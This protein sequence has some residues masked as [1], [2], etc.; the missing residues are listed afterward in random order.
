MWLSCLFAVL[1]GPVNVLSGSPHLSAEIAGDAKVEGDCQ[2]AVSSNFAV[3]CSGLDASQIA[4]IAEQQL[5]AIRNLWM[6]GEIPEKWSRPCEIVAHATRADYCAAVGCGGSIS[7][8][9]TQIK[10]DAGK[11]VHRR[12]DLLIE[13]KQLPALGHELTHVVLA[14]S[15]GGRR[16]P[17]WADEGM[18]I[19]SDESA[20]RRLHQNDLR[21]AYFQWSTWPLENLLTRATYPPAT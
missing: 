16:P 15:F 1:P 21:R 7:V 3:V 17:P 19:L 18:A 10:T 2:R 13:G 20:K 11:I 14:D 6:G 9:S 4:A 12:I 5:H 8:G